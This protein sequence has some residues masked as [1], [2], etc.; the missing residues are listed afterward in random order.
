MAT[1]PH[2]TV[3]APT[4]VTPP[5]SVAGPFVA[6]RPLPPP[7][8]ASAPTA[9]ETPIV[10]ANTAVAPAASNAAVA[11]AVAPTF[12]AGGT[13]YG[14]AKGASPLIIQ[15]TSSISLE[16]RGP[17]G[18][19]YFAHQLHAGEAYRVPALP[20]LTAEVS[21]PASAALYEN[22]VSKGPFAQ[23]VMPLKIAS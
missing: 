6:G 18:V 23:A 14:D 15:A 11:S 4:H 9:Y 16:V 21:N 5:P 12:V 13:I 19:V 1:G 20:N 8:E 3:A 10:T 2:K 17:G 7:A 22:G